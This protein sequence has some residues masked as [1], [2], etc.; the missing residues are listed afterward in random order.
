MRLPPFLYQYSLVLTPLRVFVVLLLTMD[1]HPELPV[2][3]SLV[4][5][6]LGTHVSRKLPVV[7][8]LSSNITILIK[9]PQMKLIDAGG[10]RQEVQPYPYHSIL[11]DIWVFS[12]PS[13]PRHFAIIRTRILM[14]ELVVG[15]T[16]ARIER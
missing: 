9:Q 13:I 16:A 5:C 1:L 15:Q 10:S 7:F 14:T 2:S 11:N 8:T 12:L 6:S 4:S 3:L